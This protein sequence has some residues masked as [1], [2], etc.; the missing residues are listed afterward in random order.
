MPAKLK[1]GEDDAASDRIA[2]RTL[3]Q[4]SFGVGA[5]T[6]LEKLRFRYEQEGEDIDADGNKIR[7]E[8][9]KMKQFRAAICQMADGTSHKD[10][11]GSWGWRTSSNQN[12]HPLTVCFAEA[13]ERQ[14]EPLLGKNQAKVLVA[15]WLGWYDVLC[16][17]SFKLFFTKWSGNINALGVAGGAR[18]KKD[19]TFAL[20]NVLAFFGGHTLYKCITYKISASWICS[21]MGPIIL[22]LHLLSDKFRLASPPQSE[23]AMYA[24]SAA[25]GM[26]NGV[27]AEQFKCIPYAYTGHIMKFS[28]AIAETLM[29]KTKGRRKGFKSALKSENA[30]LITAFISGAAASQAVPALLPLSPAAAA[31]WAKHKFGCMGALNAAIITA[32]EIKV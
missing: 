17:K 6:L 24:L 2:M 20:N 28:T 30:L 19:W 18:R 11:F 12:S 31:F 16:F 14:K 3:F 32:S 27:A 15:F 26:S 7:V 8:T 9:K 10:N 22:G 25:T 13:G 21:T 23:D 29:G 1:I 4:K 5:V